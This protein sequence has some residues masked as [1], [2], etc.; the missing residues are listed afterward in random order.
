MAD[1][2]TTPRRDHVAVAKEAGLGRVSLLS[3]LAGALASFGTFALVAAVAGAVLAAVD[4]DTDFA[5]NDW[6]AAGAVGVAATAVALSVSYLFGGYVAGRM[7]RRSGLLHGL[8]VVVLSLLIGLLAG[9]VVAGLADADDVERNLRSIGVPTTVDDWDEVGLA[10]AIAALAA[11]AVGGAL[12]GVLG[13]RWHTKLARRAADP[14]YGPAAE[15]RRLAEEAEGARDRDLLARDDLVGRDATLVA[16]PRDG[17][18]PVAAGGDGSATREVDLRDAGPAGGAASSRPVPADDAT[19]PL[20]DADRER[21]R[22]ASLDDA[23][24]STR[25]P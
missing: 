14:A 23:A 1:Q 3:V 11:M 10:G 16:G 2:R 6:A 24:R 21:A 9:T 22:Q 7:A 15:A 20:D 5:T 12:G 8:A 18:T 13:E 25:R 4:V 19:R 17:G